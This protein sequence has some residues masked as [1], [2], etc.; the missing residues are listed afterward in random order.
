MPF[1]DIEMQ[2]DME[3]GVNVPRIQ[4][5]ARQNGEQMSLLCEEKA[6]RSANFDSHG[7]ARFVYRWL[8][9]QGPCSGEVLV[10]LAI[11]NGFRPHDARAFGGVF[12][13][14]SR[15]QM[16]RCIG[17][18]ERAKGHGTAGA[19]LWEATPEPSD[20][21]DLFSEATIEQ[22]S[23]QAADLELSVGR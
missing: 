9:Q 3:H 15:S 10:N 5:I 14:L 17:T 23:S 4:L 21:G 20:V 8:Q 16:I 7:A 6:V 13:R 12:A 22:S 18:L 19:R 1:R 11:E 2:R